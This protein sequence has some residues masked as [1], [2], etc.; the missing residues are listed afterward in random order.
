MGEKMS[1]NNYRIVEFDDGVDEYLVEYVVNGQKKTVMVAPV[2]N[3]QRQVDAGLTKLAIQR[4]VREQQEAVRRVAVSGARD[5]VGLSE[6]IDDDAI[7]DTSNFPVGTP[8][9]AEEI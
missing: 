8:E 3:S 2:M 6:A 9:E 7:G 1:E 5:L 4:A